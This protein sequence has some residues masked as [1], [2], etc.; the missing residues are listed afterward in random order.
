MV[1]RAQVRSL[2]RKFDRQSVQMLTI[3]VGTAAPRSVPL[4]EMAQ[5]GLEHGCL[6]RIQSVVE[7]LPLVRVLGTPAMVPQQ[8]DLLGDR[9]IVRHHGARVAIGT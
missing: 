3:Q 2:V 9:F 5:L 4:L 7:T 8:T 6:K 1:R